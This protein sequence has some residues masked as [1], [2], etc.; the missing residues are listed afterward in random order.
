MKIVDIK[1]MTGFNPQVKDNIDSVS[2][3]LVVLVEF[4]Y[5]YE[6]MMIKHYPYCVIHGAMN[7]VSKDGIWRCLTDKCG[8]GCY[9]VE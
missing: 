2:K 6:M 9:Q 8:V 5:E 7:K 3:G 1:D 4:Q